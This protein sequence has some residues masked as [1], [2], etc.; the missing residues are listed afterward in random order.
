MQ[1]PQYQLEN[2]RIDERRWKTDERRLFPSPTSFVI[3]H[4][5]DDV[6][7]DVM[8]MIEK[9]VDKGHEYLKTLAPCIKE[10]LIARS[11][12]RALETALNPRP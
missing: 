7:Y 12:P 10:P 11:D 6:E 4:Y 3:T 1:D 8:G 5:A 2:G 9:N